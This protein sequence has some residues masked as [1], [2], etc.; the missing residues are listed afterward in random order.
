[1]L[2]GL[3]DRTNHNV[4]CSYTNLTRICMIMAAVSIPFLDKLGVGVSQ[5]ELAYCAGRGFPIL[6]RPLPT[7][8]PSNICQQ[9]GEGGEVVHH[10]LVCEVENTD[11]CTLH[12]SNPSST[13]GEDNTQPIR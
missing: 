12:C 8:Q 1:M 3:R 4:I 10:G 9:W 2:I 6:L 13:M 7:L 11:M 5:N